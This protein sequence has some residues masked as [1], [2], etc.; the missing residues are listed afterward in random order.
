MAAPAPLR[1]E[2]GHRQA[3]GYGAA[4]ITKEGFFS[5]PAFPLEKVVD[6]TGAGDT[7]AGELVGFIAAAGDQAIDHGLLTT[8]MAYGTPVASF[9]VEEFGTERIAWLT[10]VE[11]G[12]R[13]G[14]LHRMTQ[15]TH[16][17][18]EMTAA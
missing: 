1:T 10:A 13:V 11:I 6:P 4:A 15:F 5:L 3:G 12:A 14:E 8:A 16:T 17:S 18:L 2:R 9:N 7:F